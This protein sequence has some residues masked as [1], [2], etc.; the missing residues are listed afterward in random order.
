MEPGTSILLE[1]GLDH[2]SKSFGLLKDEIKHLIDN[3]FDEYLKKM[4]LKFLY[5]RT[6]LHRNENLNFKNL[7]Y[8]LTVV[9]DKRKRIKNPN[10]R[11]L[12]V[13]KSNCA[14]VIGNAGSGKSMLL[15][16]LFIN[17]YE[18][19]FKVPIYLELRS[20][21]S[22]ELSFKNCIVN[23]IDSN[24]LAPN[25][26]IIERIL[27]SGRFIVLLDGFDEIYSNKKSKLVDEIDSFIDSY[28]KNHFVIS[29][30]K[31]SG[32]ESIPRF[33]N[34]IIKEL[35]SKQIYEFID[36]QCW[37]LNDEELAGNIKSTIKL[38][39]KKEY[40]EYLKL[41]LLLSMFIY[42]FK[43]YPE[44]P[45]KRSKFYWNIY[46]TLA[47]KHDTV[48]KKGG[49]L[50]ERKSKLK[51][52]EIEL[53]LQWFSM[54]SFFE[55]KYEFSLSYLKKK[56]DII[57]KHTRLI[58][59]TNDLIYD[60]TTSISILKI[61]GLNYVFPHR[62][63]QEYFCSELIATQSQD[64][65]LN[66]YQKVLPN[67]AINSNDSLSNLFLLLDENDSYDFKLNFIIPEIEKF[68]SVLTSDTSNPV[69]KFYNA[70]NVREDLNHISEYSKFKYFNK[71]K[72]DNHIIFSI[73]S[74]LEI[75]L[76]WEFSLK[77]IKSTKIGYLEIN[78]EE[79]VNFSNCDV[80]YYLE[81]DN[82]ARMFISNYYKSEF[83]MNISKLK[84]TISDIK[85]RV[86]K[87]AK[88][89]SNFI[90]NSINT[91]ANNVYN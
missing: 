60:L 57:K 56:I 77:K 51:N 38:N 15:K 59:D 23:I 74:F 89:D 70:F 82:R 69:S 28:N 39:R 46:D 54:L 35:T 88:K 68:I 75:D 67:Y 78:I 65:K 20:F 21:N 40:L 71:Y 50:H 45:T 91:S 81:I 73:F 37:L 3:G 19:G 13:N 58:F 17:S 34:F 66:I 85:K 5:S 4:R 31:N 53:I 43:N 49:Y 12:F 42:T 6:F 18:E 22:N 24:N 44:L 72:F 16:H 52:D 11:N 41:P 48:S 63:L 36:I 32:L 26:K 30:R 87:L 84:D 86:L 1:K 55:G 76:N 90:L 27:K 47:T 29:S 83:E 80:L 61:D 62:S 64:A 33:N 8:P 79:Y 25:K 9:N 7:Y 2:V 14:S 10:C